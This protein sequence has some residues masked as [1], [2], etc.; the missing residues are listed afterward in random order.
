[1][2]SNSKDRTPYFIRFKNRAIQAQTGG[3]PGG[4]FTEIL[5]KS[6]CGKSYLLYELIM[7]TIAM[8]GVAMLHDVERALEAAYM[9]RVGMKEG[10]GFALSYEKKM[11]QIF[12]AS[13]EFVLKVRK[14]NSTCPILIGVDSYPP[15]QTILSQAEIEEQLKKG[16]A[17]SL[18]GYREAKKNAIFA[19]MIGEF[20]TFLDEHKATFVLLNQTR[21]AMN[22]M[23]GEGLTSN[24]DNIIQ[25][26]VTL[27]LRGEIVKSV[28]DPKTN[29]KI[30]VLTKWTTIK[31]RLVFPFKETT[32]K[33]LYKSG[34]QKM[35]GVTQ[36]LIDEGRAE[37]IKGKPGMVKVDGKTWDVKEL[38]AA[39]PEIL[40]LRETA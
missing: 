22:V 24:A 26:Y 9:K 39:K 37:K 30:G 32:T 5:G 6:Q 19:N 25:F 35:S 23:F 18:K 11:E 21:K 1:M 16:D 10:Q 31:N 29:K 20:I 38:L 12:L 2:D 28:K 27:R 8:G 3:C 14:V 17:K 15:I 33:I 13:R 34:V 4:R 40:D 7:E 36:L